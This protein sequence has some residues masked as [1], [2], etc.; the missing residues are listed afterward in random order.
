MTFNVQGISQSESKELKMPKE[1]YMLYREKNG[2]GLCYLM[3]SPWNFVA[4]GAISKEQEYWV[5]GA[6]FLQNYYSVYDFGQNKIGMVE[7]VT[8]KL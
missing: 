3:V 7:S 2:E 1:A 5:L 4:M 8:S 6:K